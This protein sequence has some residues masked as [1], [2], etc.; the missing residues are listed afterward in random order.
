MA[1]VFDFSRFASLLRKTLG[2]LGERLVRRAD[3]LRER[4][5]RAWHFSKAPSRRQIQ[6]AREAL[7]D[8][9]YYE[10]YDDL[11]R[12][13]QRNGLRTD[14][15]IKID[16][17]RD[18]IHRDVRELLEAGLIPPPGSRLLDLGCGDGGNSVYFSELGFRV[19]GVDVAPTAIEIATQQA[20][21]KG[22][23]IDYRVAD[24]TN[25]GDLGTGAFDLAVDVGCL[26][27]LVR[28]AERRGYLEGV[29]RAL[30]PDGR[31]L[32]FES[33]S[34]SD[35]SVPDEEAHIAK[36]ITLVEGRYLPKQ[37][38]YIRFRGC[39]ARTAS[40]AQYHAELHRAGFEIVRDHGPWSPES[41]FAMLLARPRR[42]E[43]ES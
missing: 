38:R 22:L 32:L 31:F 21:E 1:I 7:A 3:R 34:S 40:L 25:L 26:H 24:V 9:Q 28:D 16:Q 17:A 35:L 11:Y 41:P 6:D 37:R 30:H 42:G 10:L 8:R 4:V 15:F 43:A 19:T 27:M 12:E 14:D 18:R 39:G 5:A 2:P 20:V 29:R 13:I 23:S 33:A 36:G